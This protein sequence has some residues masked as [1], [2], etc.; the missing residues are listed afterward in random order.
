MRLERERSG[1]WT[2]KDIELAFFDRH[3][4]GRP[5]PLL[6]GPAKG[7]PEVVASSR[8]RGKRGR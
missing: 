6:D 1:G 7:Y 8:Q 4:R 2:E 5:V 3:L